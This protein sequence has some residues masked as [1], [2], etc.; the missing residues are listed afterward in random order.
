MLLNEIIELCSDV[1]KLS[2][3]VK[4]FELLMAN[5]PFQLM[6][7]GDCKVYSL[8]EEFNQTIVKHMKWRIEQL[9]AR[10]RRLK[11]LIGEDKP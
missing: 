10:L 8:D 11:A 5:K 4:E 6:V 3:Q 1:C 9:Q 2:D 7:G